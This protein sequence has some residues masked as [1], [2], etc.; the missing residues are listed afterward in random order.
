MRKQK[1]L[2]TGRCAYL[3]LSMS[4]EHKKHA[5]RHCVG[6][7]A[8]TVHISP[9][10]YQQ[11]RRGNKQTHARRR[12]SGYSNWG[13]E[14][15]STKEVRR[16]DK[17]SGPTE[18][19]VQTHGPAERKCRRMIAGA[20]AFPKFVMTGVSVHPARKLHVSWKGHLPERRMFHPRSC[21]A[22]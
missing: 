2:R 13:V 7:V 20:G 14:Q 22:K 4:R 5:T 12:Q 6:D 1:V 3:W 18:I 17:T 11:N 19:L 21:A 9:S 10:T 8:Q 15:Q 16:Q